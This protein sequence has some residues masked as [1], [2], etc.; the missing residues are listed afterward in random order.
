MVVRLVD[1]PGLLDRSLALGIGLISVL[2]KL[3]KV[4]TTRSV[5]E[6]D[7]TF[8]LDRV[9]VCVLGGA[10]IHTQTSKFTPLV[11]YKIHE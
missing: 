9:C 7:N 3:T 10:V 6:T 8:T 11:S 5:L 4:K 1:L 2:T